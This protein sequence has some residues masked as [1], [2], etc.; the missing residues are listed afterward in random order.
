VEKRIRQLR[1]KGYGFLKIGR[2][3]GVGT[4]AVQRVVGAG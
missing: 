4:S 2:E 1:K 3:L